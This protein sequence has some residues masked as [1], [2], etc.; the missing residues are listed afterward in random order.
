MTFRITSIESRPVQPPALTINLLKDVNGRMMIASFQTTK[1]GGM[2]SVDQ[3]KEC[4]DW[5]TICKWR[6]LIS[7][8]LNGLKSSVGKACHKHKAALMGHE[9]VNT[10]AHGFRPGHS[11]H[12]HH[13]NGHGHN[14]HHKMH[15]LLRRAFL[16]ILIPILVGVFA[17]TL[18]YLIGMALGC[19]IAMIVTKVR[20]R[21][22]YERVALDE[23]VEEQDSE[24]VGE[25]EIYAE[26]PTYDAPPVYEE[27]AGEQVVDETK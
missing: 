27:A 10:K 23:D 25:K 8:R 21:G 9:D 17:G 19:A 18:T 4:K 5:P 13:H 22:P 20:G 15:M 1:A 14:R 16:T 2:G 11:H 7:D 12:H 3:D 6:S 24:V 26:L